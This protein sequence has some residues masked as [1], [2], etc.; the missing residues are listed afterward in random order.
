MINTLKA[1]S[2]GLIQKIVLI[3]YLKSGCHFL[4][5]IHFDHL[6]DVG[7]ATCRRAAIFKI[8]LLLLNIVRARQCC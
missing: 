5:G 3:I 6:F 2:N 1:E 4:V 7:K 8:H